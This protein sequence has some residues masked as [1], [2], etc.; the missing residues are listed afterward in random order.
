MLW[1]DAYS[2]E[3]LPGVELP[4]EDELREHSVIL[5]LSA[6]HSLPDLEIWLKLISKCQPPVKRLAVV[7]HLSEQ[8]FNDGIE[9]FVKRS[10]ASVFKRSDVSPDWS[11]GKIYAYAASARLLMIGPPTED[12]WEEFEQ[13]LRL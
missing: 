7:T 3:I 9:L 11:K 12:A 4:L 1:R 10:Q 2:T 6:W 5:G 8:E 13:A